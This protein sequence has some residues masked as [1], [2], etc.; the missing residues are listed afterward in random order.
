MKWH[1]QAILSISTNLNSVF[2]A[3]REGVVVEWN[4]INMSKRF[5][6]RLGGVVQ[7]TKIIGSH[8]IINIDHDTLIVY[9]LSKSEV[10]FK[11]SF[12]VTLGDFHF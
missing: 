10:V 4:M 11:K 2:T 6:S 9:D 3:G 12:L 8:L 5:I 7:S 1:S